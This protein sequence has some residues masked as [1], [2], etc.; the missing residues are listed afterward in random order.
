MFITLISLYHSKPLASLGRFINVQIALCIG[1]VHILSITTFK[2][3]FMDGLCI[4]D[5]VTYFDKV[6]MFSHRKKQIDILKFIQL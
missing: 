2:K 5:T 4:E 1:N 6:V 3:N